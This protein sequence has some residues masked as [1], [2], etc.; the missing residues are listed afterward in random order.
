M[1]DLRRSDERLPVVPRNH[2]AA[3]LRQ[4]RLH[5]LRHTA[6]SV[7]LAQGVP[8]RVVMEILGHSHQRH[9]QH[10]RTRGLRG[11]A[12]SCGT[13]GRGAVVR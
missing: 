2:P 4:V 12:G 3:G 8:A 6:A 10:L 11:R 9:S 1:P 13:A 5:D 7:L